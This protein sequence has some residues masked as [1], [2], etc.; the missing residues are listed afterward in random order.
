MAQLAPNQTSVNCDASTAV[1]RSVSGGS[2]S[3]AASVASA[4]GRTML[5][6][7]RGRLPS[8]DDGRGTAV[9]TKNGRT[10]DEGRDTGGV[11]V[12]SGVEAVDESSVEKDR[13]R[14]MGFC[15]SVAVDARPRSCGSFAS[16]ANGLT[17]AERLIVSTRCEERIGEEVG[18]GPEHH[19]DEQQQQALNVRLASTVRLRLVRRSACDWL[20]DVV[21]GGS[22][23]DH[24]R[25]AELGKAAR[26]KK[27]RSETR[28]LDAAR[29]RCGLVRQSAGSRVGPRWQRVMVRRERQRDG[30]AKARRDASFRPR[31]SSS[32]RPSSE[33]GLHQSHRSSTF[34]D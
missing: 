25:K 8:I 16:T 12:S 29:A 6:D 11:G 21:A 10:G 34:A 1:W 28:E 30:V 33:C 13:V 24:E 5:M 4:E 23:V 7:V 20:V 14:R 26:D 2:G 17:S 22:G 18:G 9:E 27:R 32:D 15:L 19:D 3:A 31:L